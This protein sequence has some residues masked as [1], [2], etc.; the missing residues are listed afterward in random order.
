MLLGL[1]LAE[2][3]ALSGRELDRWKAYHEVEPIPRAGWFE[4]QI[5]A[6]VANANRTGGKAAKAED[7]LPQIERRRRRRGAA[8]SVKAMEAAFRAAVEG[9]Q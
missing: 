5:C 2:V 7:F 9:I 6:V 1:S 4:A 8:R 3:E